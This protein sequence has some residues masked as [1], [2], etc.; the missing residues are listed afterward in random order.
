MT[1]SYLPPSATVL[2]EAYCCA[3]PPTLGQGGIRAASTGSQDTTSV[4]GIF[5]KIPQPLTGDVIGRHA[6]SDVKSLS[7]SLQMTAG[8]K[9]L[10]CA[11]LTVLFE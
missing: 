7:P 10:C 9:L 5:S 8:K 1:L 11:Q 4:G 2:V 6:A 3:A